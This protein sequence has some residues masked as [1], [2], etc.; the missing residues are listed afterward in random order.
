MADLNRFRRLGQQFTQEGQDLIRRNIDE[1][2]QDM[3]QRAIDAEAVEKIKA[4]RAA[5]QSQQP[6]APS[7]PEAQL[8][9]MTGQDFNSMMSAMDAQIELNRRDKAMRQQMEMED[10]ARK[11]QEIEQAN[12]QY[13][14]Y[15]RQEQPEIGNLTTDD[16][17]RFS[18]LKQVLQP[19][20]QGMIELSEDPEEMQ[21]QIQRAR[22][23]Q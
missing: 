1:P 12:A 15:K 21:R 23:G 20:Q 3:R 16:M 11:L 18:R 10:A 6:I 13:Q 14:P 2:V 17:Q 8:G 9:A 7:Q 19:P 4:M 22:L 5:Q